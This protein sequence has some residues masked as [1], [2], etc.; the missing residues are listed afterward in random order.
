ML[1]QLALMTFFLGWSAAMVVAGYLLCLWGRPAILSHIQ[2]MMAE[3]KKQKEREEAMAALL[4][5]R[6]APAAPPAAPPAN[7]GS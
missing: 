7:Q 1:T 6:P 2:E 4:A 5:A 3:A